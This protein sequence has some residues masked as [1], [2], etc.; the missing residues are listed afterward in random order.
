MGL[1]ALPALIFTPW[2][3]IQGM[4]ERYVGRAGRTRPSP[5]DWLPMAEA[6]VAQ[7]DLSVIAP[8]HNEEENVAALVEE[9]RRALQPLGRAFEVIIVDDGSTDRTRARVLELMAG[10]PWLRCIAMTRTPQGKGAGQSAAFYAGFA[11]AR[12]RLIA[13]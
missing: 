6:P 7:P 10:R 12:G 5:Y 4:V 3:C 13:T 1:V 11:Q 8:A 2:V 9:I